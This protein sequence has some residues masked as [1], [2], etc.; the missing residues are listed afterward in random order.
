[1][2]FLFPR[3]PFPSPIEKEWFLLFLFPCR[4]FPGVAGSA[5]RA[6]EGAGDGAGGLAMTGVV[7]PTGAGAGAGGWAMIGVALS[8]GAGV[9]ASPLIAA[10]DRFPA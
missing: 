10:P 1:M 9:G 4:P 5:R 2:L 3:R 6:G 7:P 8:S